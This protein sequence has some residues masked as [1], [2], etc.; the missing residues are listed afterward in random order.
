MSAELRGP[1]YR[2]ALS[3]AYLEL[4][5]ICERIAQ[6][7]MRKEQLE[8]ASAALQTMMEAP[9]QQQ[10]M[11]PQIE[12]REA[13]PAPSPA[14]VYEMPTHV[15][16]AERQRESPADPLQ[17]HIDQALGMAALA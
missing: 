12:V 10:P 3:E 9:A 7:R 11:A 8:R 6:L 14:P 5:Q 17:R 16:I 2:A 4:D 1:A 13:V 15:P